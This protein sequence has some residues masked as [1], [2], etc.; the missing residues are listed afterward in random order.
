MWYHHCNNKHTQ[1][2]K[3]GDETMA[4][5]YDIY[6]PEEIEI[7]HDEYVEHNFMKQKIYALCMILFS[8]LTIPML[9]GELTIAFIIIPIMIYMLFSRKY[10]LYF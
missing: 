6:D 9:G 7:I 8:L 5:N 10:W 4:K 1:T 2:Q 3:Q